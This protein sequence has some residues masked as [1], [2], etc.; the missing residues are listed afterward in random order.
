MRM[1][2]RVISSEQ[3]RQPVGIQDEEAI[4]MAQ[5]AAAAADET[6]ARCHGTGDASGWPARVSA[7]LDLER[8]L[9]ESQKA[10]DLQAEIE[11]LCARVL[12]FCLLSS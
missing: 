4:A 11:A 1:H 5:S 6:S 8:V 3:P 2:P 7:R 10:F 9:L 12:L